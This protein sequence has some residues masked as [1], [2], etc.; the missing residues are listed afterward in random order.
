ML[1]KISKE[2]FMM[3]KAHYYHEWQL[4]IKSLPVLS[5]IVFELQCNTFKCTMKANATFTID[6]LILLNSFMENIFTF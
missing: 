6:S 5:L 2:H 3:L 1:K 4:N